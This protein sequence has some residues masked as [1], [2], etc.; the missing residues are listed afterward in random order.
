MTAAP[1]SAAVVPAPDLEALPA[2]VAALAQRAGEH[3]R[4]ATFPFEGIEAVR[5]A[6]L[7]TTTVAERYGGP[8]AGVLDTARVLAELGRGDPSAKNP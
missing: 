7:L 6:G 5:A 4:D 8:G 3:D 2:I 1:A